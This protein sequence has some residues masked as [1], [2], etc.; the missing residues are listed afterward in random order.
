M[1][2]SLLVIESILQWLLQLLQKIFAPAAVVAGVAYLASG[3]FNRAFD[4]DLETY[5][6]KLAQ[7]REKVVG[8]VSLIQQKRAD[9]VGKLYSKIA[10]AARMI[11]S[12][13]S[14]ALVKVPYEHQDVLNAVDAFVDV[15]DYFE[16][17][18]IYVT[19]EI[20]ERFGEL[21]EG[22]ESVLIKF[23]SSER[24]TPESSRRL[25]TEA[26]EEFKKK[27]PPLQKTLRAQMGYLIGIDKA[28][29]AGNDDAD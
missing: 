23:S 19:D 8:Q 14:G 17:N 13:V 4:R 11:G 9:V 22:V 15:R 21:R 5:K 20:R 18:S 12:L 10:R 26:D 29:L 2:A 28:D 1:E 27:W 3:W 6:S 24:A 7:E 16:E 25:L